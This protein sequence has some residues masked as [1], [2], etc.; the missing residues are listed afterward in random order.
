[1]AKKRF[2]KTVNSYETAKKA[3]LVTLGMGDKSY[4]DILP[5]LENEI[6]KSKQMHSFH[7]KISCF[8]EDGAYQLNKSIEK[9]YGVS[10]NQGEKTPSNGDQPVEMLD[11]KL[12]NGDRIKVPFGNIATP[13]FGKDSTIQIAYENDKNLLHIKGT[14]QFQYNALIDSIINET[15]TLL[16]TE[17]I[18]KNQAFELDSNFQPKT[19]NLDNIDKE[20]MILNESTEIELIP[21]KSRILHPQKCLDKKIPLKFGAL[22]EGPYGW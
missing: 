7:Y 8:K 3:E 13:E 9:I 5:Y 14:C 21:L 2:S 16:N 4:G 10:I 15:E 17:S 22:L 1:M 20:F 11:V 6:L 18:Y 12:S 19:L